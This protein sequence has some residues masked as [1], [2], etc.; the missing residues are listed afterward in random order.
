MTESP[1]KDSKYP[2][3][4]YARSGD[5]DN[6]ESSESINPNEDKRVDDHESSIDREKGIDKEKNED[7]GLG[8]DENLTDD[9]KEMSIPKTAKTNDIEASIPEEKKDPLQRHISDDVDHALPVGEEEGLLQH[10]N[11]HAG[12][13]DSMEQGISGQKI[14]DQNHGAPSPILEGDDIL[15]AADEADKA[16]IRSSYVGTEQAPSR[17]LFKYNP[18]VELAVARIVPIEEDDELRPKKKIIIATQHAFEYDPD[19][20]ARKKSFFRRRA[21]LL[22]GFGILGITVIVLLAVLMSRRDDRTRDNA[23]SMEPTPSP[24]TPSPTVST[25]ESEILKSLKK[26]SAKVEVEETPYHMA[27]NWILYDDPSQ[28]EVGDIQLEQRFALAVLYYS[29]T[30]NGSKPWNSCNPFNF[31]EGEA[32]FAASHN[33]LIVTIDKNY[34]TVMQRVGNEKWI[35]GT[36]KNRWLSEANECNWNG[37]LCDNEQKVIQSIILVGQ[38][39]TGNLDLRSDDD[40]DDCESESESESEND[41][42]LLLR[43]M[44]DLRRIGLHYNS[45]TGTIPSSY[46]RFSNLRYLELHGNKLTGEIP[47]S[48][49]TKLTSVQLLNLGENELEGTLSTRIGYLSKLEGLHLH[50][51]DFWGDFPT[52]IGELSSLIY[53]RIHDNQFS[54]PLPTEMGKLTSLI[55]LMYYNNEF[56]VG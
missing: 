20:V 13:A 28:L 10:N 48:F 24:T 27:A 44:P 45:L 17:A 40:Y 16:K 32:D 39:L 29:T 26:L 50:D 35:A 1:H 49:Y 6:P 2:D 18:D 14:G 47:P 12:S 33:V 53:S 19:E 51:N 41:C 56:S 34:C 4:V 37:V 11:S 21:T 36:S 31:S 9:I 23:S 25:R 43:T 30:S 5:Q 42:H 7:L 38:N 46:A 22:V 8:S 55:L 54:G 52:E 3:V 15:A